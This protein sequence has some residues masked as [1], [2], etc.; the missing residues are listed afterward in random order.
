MEDEF[1]YLK[2]SQ[3]GKVARGILDKTGKASGFLGSQNL[4]NLFAT[5]A[6]KYIDK[7]NRELQAEQA[8]NINQ[9]TSQYNSIL[10]TRKDYFNSE[11]IKKQRQDFQ[12]WSNPETKEFAREEK[13]REY[14]N[15][16]KDMIELFQSQNPYGEYLKL[17]RNAKN[18]KLMTDAFNLLKGQADIY[19]ESITDDAI[20]TPTQAEYLQEVKDSFQAALKEAENDPTKKSY[21]TKQFLKSFGRDSKGNPRF[22]LVNQ[23][24]L[25]NLRKNAEEA[26]GIGRD[27]A[28]G[29]I[30]DLDIKQRE[31]EER[32]ALARP[33]LSG[34]DFNIEK[35]KT[36]RANADDKRIINGSLDDRNNYFNTQYPFTITN[37][38]GKTVKK[39][40]RDIYKN[41]D[42]YNGND[43]MEGQYNENSFLADI[44]TISDSLRTQFEKQNFAGRKASAEQFLIPAIEQVVDRLSS[45]LPSFGYE[46]ILQV[47]DPNQEVVF[48]SDNKQK[49]VTYSQ[50]EDILKQFE[51]EERLEWIENAQYDK[52]YNF[53][54]DILKRTN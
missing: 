18:S 35:P 8:K 54:F 50:L 13:A 4:V 53:I 26:A 43:S 40:F 34:F 31:V 5:V 19:F 22:G 44:F 48:T 23:D 12:R 11:S 52:E 10:G 49:K 29:I 27:N 28:L 7:R 38:K 39:S 9:L 14:F 37:N 24:E 15:Q 41:I 30:T 17:P 6:T 20:I 47:I 16:D 25:K 21:L 46:N 51:P 42:K 3:F 32:Q 33:D 1:D 2:D 36:S 45:G